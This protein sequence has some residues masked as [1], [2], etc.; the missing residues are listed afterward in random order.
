[1]GRSNDRFLSSGFHSPI[2]CAAYRWAADTAD[3]DI[4]ALLDGLY[5][6]AE[7]GRERFQ[8]TYW[9]TVDWRLHA[10]GQSL[11]VETGSGPTTLR[12]E[13]AELDLRLPWDARRSP[14]FAG[15]LPAG[16][17]ER[18]VSRVAWVRRLL[19]V[20]TVGGERS[21]RHVLDGERK[22][23]VRLEIL[24]AVAAAPRSREG[25]PLEVEIVVKGVRGY[26]RAFKD[27]AALIAAAEGVHAAEGSAL[28]QA[29]A[30]LGRDPGTEAA[31]PAFELSPD[32]SA[33]EATRR[34]LLALL[35]RVERNEE[36]TRKDLDSEYLH[37]LRVAVRQSRSALSQIKGVLPEEAMARFRRDLSW[38]GKATGPTR[39]LDVYLLKMPA[40]EADLPEEARAH[41]E[42]LATFL[43]ELQRKEQRKLRRVLSSQRYKRFKQGWRS[44]LEEVQTAASALTNAERPAAELASERIN[45][46]FKRVLKR[47]SAITEETPAQA[48][49]DLRIECKKLRY[50]ITFF[51]DLFLPKLIGKTISDLKGLQDNLG[52]FNDLEVQQ[53]ALSA[54]ARQMAAEAKAPPET[55]LAMGRLVE[56]LAKRQ[57]DERERFAERFEAFASQKNRDRFARLFGGGSR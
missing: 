25:Q 56:L 6:V 55:I 54:F 49:H 46:I 38:L 42:P 36:G 9:D 7:A 51:S 23:V 8:A 52:D 17:M 57:Q 40:Y 4:D 50:L 32:M 12:L 21:H 31:K 30:L 53:D 28:A 22:T 10:H 41:I 29:L 5:R 48:L 13:G 1:V 47:G 24:R 20:A 35:R 14:A 2:G 26:D 44:Y 33:G 37:Q 19:P 3:G 18:A 15:D 45:K 39:D 43:R 11:A 16:V 34:V 27:V